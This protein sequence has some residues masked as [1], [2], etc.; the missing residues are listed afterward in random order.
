ME[1]Y[2]FSPKP[3]G[4]GKNLVTQT[5][6]PPGLLS[7][8]PYCERWVRRTPQYFTLPYDIWWEQHY[9]QPVPSW[10]YKKI[11][12]SEIYIIYVDILIIRFPSSGSRFDLVR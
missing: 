6:F 3:E 9:N 2:F 4:K 8:P 12:T 1:K 5:E 10:N 11:R 7:P